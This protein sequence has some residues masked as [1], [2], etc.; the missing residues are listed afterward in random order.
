MDP[1]PDPGGPKTC[2]FGSPTLT[3]SAIY[4]FGTG[5]VFTHSI[6]LNYSALKRTG[7]ENNLMADC[8]STDIHLPMRVGGCF[9][10]GGMSEA[11]PLKPSHSGKFSMSP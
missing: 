5:M 1:D 7:T 10:H 11:V 9:L 4:G 8:Y 6:S 2:G 3:E